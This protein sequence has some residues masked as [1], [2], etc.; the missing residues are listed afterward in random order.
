MMVLH[1]LLQAWCSQDWWGR[2]VQ[3]LK[4]S[5]FT[6]LQKP[7]FVGMLW[8]KVDLLADLGVHCIPTPPDY[9]LPS[10]NLNC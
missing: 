7:N 9:G 6:I 3:D 5:T 10:S 2:G 4:K 1:S 8:L